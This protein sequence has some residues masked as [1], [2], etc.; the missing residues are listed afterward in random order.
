MINLTVPLM[1]AAY[2]QQYNEHCSSVT[3]VDVQI[4]PTYERDPYNH[5]PGENLQRMF[6]GQDIYIF[7]L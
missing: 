3:T 1:P 2:S 6:P 7:L 5:Q 4:G